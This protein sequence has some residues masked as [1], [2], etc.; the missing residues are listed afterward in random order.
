MSRAEKRRLGRRKRVTPQE[1]RSYIEE[2]CD[3]RQT[4]WS[5]ELFDK[6]NDIDWARL[7]GLHLQLVE[8]EHLR[9]RLEELP[10]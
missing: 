3:L 2:Q 9:E 6:C 10:L 5:I 7:L 8:L 4:E 1:I